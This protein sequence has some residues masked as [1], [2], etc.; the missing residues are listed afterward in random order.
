M[1][2]VQLNKLMPIS[3]T[4][5]H[6]K[7]SKLGKKDFCRG[8]LS[9][10]LYIWQCFSYPNIPGIWTSFGHNSF[11]L[12]YMYTFQYATLALLWVWCTDGSVVEFSPAT[13]EARVRFPVSAFFFCFVLFL[14][15]LSLAYPEG[16]SCSPVSV[17][18][19]LKIMADYSWLSEFCVDWNSCELNHWSI[20]FATQWSFVHWCCSNVCWSH[21]NSH[22]RCTVFW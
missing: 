7:H 5:C 13:R 1:L 8:S 22:K 12:L 17:I 11:I 6:D 10:S 14:L 9:V 20:T 18:L 19:L 16:L 21:S 15:F 4:S 2:T 3:L